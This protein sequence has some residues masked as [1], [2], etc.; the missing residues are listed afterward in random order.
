MAGFTSHIH[1][2]LVQGQDSD[3][4]EWSFLPCV[5]GLQTSAFLGS[6]MP[7]PPACFWSPLHFWPS[8]PFVDPR[9]AHIL[10][11]NRKDGNENLRYP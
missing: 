10:L 7:L 5:N 8:I 4:C 11:T 3:M 2:M 1:S 9:L 6:G